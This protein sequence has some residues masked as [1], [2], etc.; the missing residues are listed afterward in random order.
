VQA[1]N[2][3]K[4]VREVLSKKVLSKKFETP[5]IGAG[6]KFPSCGGVSPRDGVVK[7]LVQQVKNDGSTGFQ[8]VVKDL[9][10]VRKFSISQLHRD[11]SLRVASDER[12]NL[13]AII[14]VAPATLG[15]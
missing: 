13:S 4:E 7:E 14:K 8:G 6:R 5:W 1:I 12:Q 11:S 2:V 9:L 15:N 3:R 10:C